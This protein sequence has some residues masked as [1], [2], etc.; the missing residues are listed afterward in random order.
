MK[1]VLCYGDSNTWG[2][3][4]ITKGRYGFAERW[5]GVLQARLGQ[6][7]RVYENGLNGRTTVF[8]DP[9]EEGR[10]GRA[11][12]EVSLMVNAP[13]D[14]LILM[15]GVNDTKNRFAK[16]PW[17]IALGMDLLIQLAQRSATGLNGDPPRILVLSPARMTEEWGDSMH[18]TIFSRYSV[19]KCNALA[20][21]YAQVAARRGCWYLDAA[22]WA[23]AVTDGV[24][25]SVEGHCALGEA[26][27]VKVQEIWGECACGC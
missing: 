27:A 2:R 24:H 23:T 11:G 18:P 6:D 3:N 13:L 9:I 15:L 5:P 7:A 19:E 16:E 14:L 25:L 26:V 8:E 4:P 12:F 17:D 21:L 20:P 1:G 10:N 22:R